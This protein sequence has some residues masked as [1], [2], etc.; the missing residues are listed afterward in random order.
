LFLTDVLGWFL[1]LTQ[2]VS[3]FLRTHWGF[4]ESARHMDVTY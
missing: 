3:S 1:D 4:V 2:E